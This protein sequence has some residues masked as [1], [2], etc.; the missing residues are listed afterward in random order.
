MKIFYTIT[1]LWHRFLY[2]SYYFVINV[3]MAGF[4]VIQGHFVNR[5]AYFLYDPG[6]SG[7]RVFGFKSARALALGFIVNYSSLFL[8]TV[9]ILYCVS[10]VAVCVPAGLLFRPL[11]LLFQFSSS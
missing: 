4:A 2:E 3:F 8:F 11:L 6:G 7:Y 10:V 5:A 1:E 9:L